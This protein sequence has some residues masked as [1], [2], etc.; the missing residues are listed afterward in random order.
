MAK[1]SADDLAK[2]KESLSKTGNLPDGYS[3]KTQ[4]TGNS[5]NATPLECG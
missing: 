5:L 1:L 3:L 2:V 4:I